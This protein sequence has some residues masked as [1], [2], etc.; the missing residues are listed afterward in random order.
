M[1]NI[2]DHEDPVQPATDERF[3]TLT[4][5]DRKFLLPRVRNLIHCHHGKLNA[6]TADEMAHLLNVRERK[7]RVALLYLLVEERIPIGSSVGAPKGYYVIESRMEADEN[8]ATLDSRM[9]ETRLRRKAIDEIAAAH[10]GRV[11]QPAMHL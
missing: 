3:Y 7:V 9:H 6:I 4:E 10:F 8:L 11:F 2:D 5:D 1:V